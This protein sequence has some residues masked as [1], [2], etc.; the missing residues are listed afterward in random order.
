M[1]SDFQ[2][3]IPEIGTIVAK[4]Q[5]LVIL[6][7]NQ[8]R[9]L[10]DALRRRCLHLFIDFPTL[11]QELDVVRV[12]VPEVTEKLAEQVVAFVQEA[13]TMA[14]RKAPGLSE[15]LDWARSL[16][17][18][19]VQTLGEEEVARTLGAIIKNEGDAHRTRHAI[20]RLLR[21]MDR[22]LANWKGYEDGPGL[23]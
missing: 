22:R 10:S 1:L 13:R 11:D 3:S 12:R 5:P 23:N 19:N 20:P 2:V 8:A 9:D 14:L 7:S 4:T 15:T 21:R 16:A 17:L 6:T 18:L